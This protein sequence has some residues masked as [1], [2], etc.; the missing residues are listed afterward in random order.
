MEEVSATRSY[1]TG[2]WWEW[3]E[4]HLVTEPKPHRRRA[5]VMGFISKRL[6]EDFL[7]HNGLYFEGAK[8]GHRERAAPYNCMWVTLLLSLPAVTKYNN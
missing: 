3:E 5:F 4:W 6:T 2:C 1:S 8:K 7:L